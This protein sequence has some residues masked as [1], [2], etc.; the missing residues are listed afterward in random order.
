MELIKFEKDNSPQP[1]NSTISDLNFSRLNISSTLFIYFKLNNC[2]TC[3]S[4]KPSIFKLFLLTKWII[5]PIFWELQPYVF[6]HLSIAS[7]FSFK[8]LLLQIGQFLGGFI[9]VFNLLFFL[10]NLVTYGITSPALSIST[11]SK[12]FIFFYLFHQNY[13]K[14]H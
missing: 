11:R 14:K 8:T 9:L 10:T 1:S 4:P 12:T 7:S 2:L 6:V 3:F 5:L 13:V